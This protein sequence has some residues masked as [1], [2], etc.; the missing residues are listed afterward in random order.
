VVSLPLSLGVRQ[1]PRKTATPTMIVRMAFNPSFFI[2][3]VMELDDAVVRGIS[4]SG[5]GGGGAVVGGG[6]SGSGSDDGGGLGFVVCFG[7]APPLSAVGEPM[8]N[9]AVAMPAAARPATTAT[10]AS[11][12]S[13]GRAARVFLK[14]ATLLPGPGHNHTAIHCTIQRRLPRPRLTRISLIPLPLRVKHL[15]LECQRAASGERMRPLLTIRPGRTSLSS[16][17]TRRA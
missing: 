5:G 17:K 7:C 14:R 11:R 15:F 6:A 9:V 12:P 16:R 3:G 10:T 4:G 8:A 13:H 1:S 2:S